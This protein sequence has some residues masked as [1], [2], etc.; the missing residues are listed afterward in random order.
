MIELENKEHNMSFRV[1]RILVAIRDEKR[2]PRGQL[3]KAATLARASG[4]RLELFHAINEPQALDALRRGVVAG[5]PTREIMNEITRRSE[6]RLTK[7]GASK[8]LRGLKVT[9]AATWDFPPHEAVIRRVLASD[10]DLVVAAAQP[11]EV[12]GRLLLANTDWELIR[13]CPCPVLVVKSGGA[14]RRPAVIAA[15]DPFHAHD[16]PAALDRQILEAGRYIARELRGTA[17][18]FHAYMPLTLVVPASA[19]QGLALMLPPEAEDVHSAQVAKM[20]ESVASR[21]GIPP[22][23]QHLHMG[24]VAD[25]LESVVKGTGAQIVAMGAV[26]RSGMRKFFIGST[27]ERVLDRLNCDLL[28]VKPRGFKT[29]VA[30]QISTAWLRG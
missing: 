3:Q 27:A 18:A 21:Y 13:H 19:S 5:H 14:Y 4:A 28:I 20:F 23:R 8:E 17:H 24:V 16:K 12:G 11:R 15:I 26:S 30:R 6:Q 7:L 10:A 2:V 22:R 1:R 25:E 9:C 29:R